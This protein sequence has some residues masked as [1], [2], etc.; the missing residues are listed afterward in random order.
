MMDPTAAHADDAMPDGEP[1]VGAH[2]ATRRPGYV[3][4]GIY[5]GDGNVIHYAGWSRRA[6][7][8]PVEVITLDGFRAGFGL[9]VI[10]HART[11]YDGA[12][13]ARRAASRLGECRYR[14]LTN[15]CEHFCL[16]CLFGVGRSEQVA[17]CLRNPVH[18]IA[19][20]VMLAACMLAARWHPAMTARE[21]PVRCTAQF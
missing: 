16:W 20:A 17:S 11:L 18:G 15:N 4:H 3:H 12:E 5:I 19:V 13:V 21:C 6:S 1:P 9:A 10:R 2:L 7:G 8:G 14:L